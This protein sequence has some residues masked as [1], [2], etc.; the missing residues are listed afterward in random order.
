MESEHGQPVEA[1]KLFPV[2][3]QK[4]TEV[5]TSLKEDDWDRHTIAR[6][7]SVKDVAAHLLD[8]NL[9]ALSLQRD[10]N[11]RIEAPKNRSYKD[12]VKWLNTTNAEWVVTARRLSPQVLIFL[13]EQTSQPLTDYFA[14][15]DADAPS[16][17]PVDW[18]GETESKNRLHVAREYSERWLHQ[19]Q[20]RDAVNKQD[21][22]T[23][24]LFYPFMDTMMYGMP[25]TFRKTEAKDGTTVRV[26]VTGEAG[27]E[28]LV[29]LNGNDWQLHKNA[30]MTADSEILIDPDTAWKLFSKGITPATAK[31]KITING[32]EKLADTALSMVSVMA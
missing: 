14:S 16:L 29:T 32:D 21:I 31:R 22:M 23:K 19:Q 26:E 17:Y 8:G 9:R 25:Y 12:V 7:W 1:K 3:Q 27:G 15:L 5:L 2:I 20:I 4:L 10:G 13:L 18:A 30:G 28:W 24:E 6:L 11:K